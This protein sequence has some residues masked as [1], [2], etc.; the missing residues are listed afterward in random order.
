MRSTRA[1]LPL[2]VLLLLGLLGTFSAGRLTGAAVPG[3][4]HGDDPGACALDLSRAFRDVSARVGPAVVS[5]RAFGLSARRGSGESRVLQQGSGVIVRADGIVVTN[6][7]VVRGGETFSV[8]LA[9]GREREVELVGSDPDADLAVL[10]LGG[11]S[12]AVAPLSDDGELAVGEWVLAMG[13]PH[14]LG[15]TV[16]AGIVSGKE[17]TN[18]GITTFEDFIQTD[19]AINMGNSGGPLVDLRGRVVGINTAVAT[20]TSGSLGIGF[21]IP[22]SM[23]R[24]VVDDIL[25]NGR[26]RRGWLGVEMR[27]ISSYRTRASHYQGE[28]RIE[29]T[30]IFSESPAMEAGL[31]VGDIVT[32][33][34]GRAV[35]QQQQLMNAIGEL[36]PG[37]KVEIAVWRAGEELTLEVVL[38]ERKPSERTEE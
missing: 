35:F 1:T 23:V 15:Q 30:R 3:A 26:V 31:E 29:L 24:R 27:P 20:R 22:A 11:G 4:G 17:R 16:T 28:S 14:G 13:N 5:V 6:H 9:D 12:P 36:E 34:S 2:P 10:R 37:A 8:L 19:A 25:A 32:S 21:A 18:L 33:I 38:N 7:H